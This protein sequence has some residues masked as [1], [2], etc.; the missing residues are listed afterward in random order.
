VVDGRADRVVAVKGTN[1][2][3]DEV[4]R[5]IGALPGVVE[6]AV[7]PA[8]APDGG[9]MVQAH[10]V[11]EIDDELLQQEVIENLGSAAR[12]RVMRHR[13]LPRTQSGKV[14]HQSLREVAGQ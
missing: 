3:L 12:P 4:E 11:G 5:L 13:E 10:L 9:A 1:V 2:D 6:C 8:A 14:A 7:L